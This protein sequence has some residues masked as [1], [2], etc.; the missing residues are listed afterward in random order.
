MFLSGSWGDRKDDKKEKER[1]ESMG[2][3]SRIMGNP[4]IRAHQDAQQELRGDLGGRLKVTHSKQQ[5]ASS[6][7]QHS[8]GGP[9]RSWEH[10]LTRSI[11]P[12]PRLLH[13]L[14][15]VT[16]WA[17]LRAPPLGHSQ[18]IHDPQSYKQGTF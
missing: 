15:L 6:L 16:T 5:S 18:G 17:C 2:R 10:R 8:P 7:T 13:E 11:H 9:K 1:A 3:G 12:P 14:D 4:T